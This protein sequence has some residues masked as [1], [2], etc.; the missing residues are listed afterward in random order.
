MHHRFATAAIAA[1]LVL[2]QSGIAAADERYF[3][4]AKQF[5]VTVPTGWKTL[6]T[7][8]GMIDLVLSSPRF[9][10]TMGLCVLISRDVSDTRND[11]QAKIDAEASTQINDAFWR[12]VMTDKNTKVTSVQSKSEVRG[13]RRV[14]FGTVGVTSTLD[15]KDV[16]LQIEMVLHVMPG[17]GMMAQCGVEISQVELEKADIQTIINSYNSTGTGV[18]ASADPHHQHGSTAKLSIT[19]SEALTAGAKD[20]IGRMAHPRKP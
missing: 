6:A 13:G 1:A 5:E 10:K 8:G 9:E 19:L 17:K 16:N 20:M 7:D 12:E 4:E 18:V 15:G 14:Y 11:S 3:N 2:G